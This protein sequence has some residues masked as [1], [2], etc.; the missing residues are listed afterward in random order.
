MKVFY[1]KDFQRVLK[2]NEEIEREYENYK[3]SKQI[4]CDDLSNKC[5]ELMT[6]NSK[7]KNVNAEIINENTKIKN[8]KLELEK[9]NKSLKCSKGGFTKKINELSSENLELKDKVKKLEDEI[10]DLKSNRYILK[11][12]PSGKTPVQKI[13]AIRPINSQVSKLQRELQ[14]VGKAK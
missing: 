11:K 2:K 4:E 6:E 9:E 12:I 14:V 10:K 7:F 13:K 1:K 8:I 5:F 3:L